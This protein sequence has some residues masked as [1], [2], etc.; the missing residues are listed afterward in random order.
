M[1]RHR[2]RSGT[3]WTISLAVHFIGL[4]VLASAGLLTKESHRPPSLTV[5]IEQAP[6]VK[7]AVPGQAG[8]APPEK[9]ARRGP[10]TQAPPD[11]NGTD[12]FTAANPNRRC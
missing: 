5:M 3:P 9:R 7:S 2:I 10:Q 1:N 12:R 11:N 4:G 8:L 6:E